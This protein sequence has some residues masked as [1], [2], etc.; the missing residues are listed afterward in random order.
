MIHLSVV[1]PCYNEAKSI[2]YLI[3]KC[4]ESLV[5][6]FNIEFIF[7]D[8]GSNDS[9]SDIL[10]NLLS[11]PENSFGKL[12]TVKKNIGYGNGII[13]GLNN[14]NGEIYAW[15]HADLQT[16][17]KDVIN[18]Y[19]KFKKNLLKNYSFVKGIRVNRNIFDSFFTFGMSIISSLLLKKKL[20][21]VNAQP[22]MFNK[23]FFDELVNPPLDFSLDLFFYYQA[24]N[25]NL[26]IETFPVYFNKRHSGIDK[27]GGTI[28][29]KL[30]LIKRTFKY[31][32]ELRNKLN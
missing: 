2:P 25:K 5:Q 29:G 26:K 3:Q 30:K 28:S 8:N 1:I 19:V 15:T 21:D 6:E 32:L 12:V 10:T 16:D 13:Q 7:V 31:I 24:L 11:K 22:K 4:K 17:P 27:G 20:F 23:I 18:A 14:A 9:S